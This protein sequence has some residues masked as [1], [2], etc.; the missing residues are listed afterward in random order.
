MFREILVPLDG[1]VQA[2]QALPHAVAIARTSNATVRLL[3]V[4]GDESRVR[5]GNHD[6]ADTEVLAYFNEYLGIQARRV[7]RS[8]SKSVPY[9]VLTGDPASTILRYVRDCG[10]DLVVLTTHGQGWLAAARLGSVADEL[11]RQAM[12]PVLAVRA[13]ESNVSWQDPGYR[14]ILVPLDGSRR[15]ETAL[16]PALAMA[17]ASRGRVIALA[18]VKLP[19]PRADGALPTHGADEAA[20]EHVRAQNY[21][22]DVAARVGT[23]V[24]VNPV[25]RA[26]L[27][28]GLAIADAAS[29][30]EAD[31]VVMSTRGRS[32][33]V[34]RR[35][36]S[37]ADMVLRGVNLPVLILKDVREPE[38]VPRATA[39]VALREAWR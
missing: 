22:R 31:L 12:V 23:D 25:V 17:R 39:D 21:V 32:R 37:T 3:H 18:V 24:L 36:G 8:L 26:A 27:H 15:A 28:P 16:E 10:C 14:R 30:F 34:R 19:Q 1:S 20:E 4:V 33:L 5:D 29:Q 13:H 7:S 35:L 11:M 2:E 6:K 38:T 9:E